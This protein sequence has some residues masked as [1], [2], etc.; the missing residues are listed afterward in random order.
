MTFRILCRTLLGGFFMLSGV[1]KILSPDEFQMAL[2]NYPLMNYQT[3]FL[4]AQILPFIELFCGLGIWFKRLEIW[5]LIQITGLLLLFIVMLSWTWALGLDINCGCLGEIDP[6][7]GQPG[8]IA[9]D[10]VLIG[11]AV[12]LLKTSRFRIISATTK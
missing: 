7:K 1:L 5:G 3:S 10:I 11:L 12:Y 9:R 6:I 8:L 4:V 2:L